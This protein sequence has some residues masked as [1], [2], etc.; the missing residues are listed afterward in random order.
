MPESSLQAADPRLSLGA[1]KP[2]RDLEAHVL[3]ASPFSEAPEP[4][5]GRTP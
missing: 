3:R 1:W 2:L 4:A 5:L